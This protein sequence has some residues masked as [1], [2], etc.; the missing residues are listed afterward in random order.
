[1][2]TLQGLVIL[3]EAHCLPSN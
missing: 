3:I 1:M 2:I